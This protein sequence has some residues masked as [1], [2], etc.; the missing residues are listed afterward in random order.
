[1]RTCIQIPRTHAK[2]GKAAVSGIPV[3]RKQDGF[4]EPV[5]HPA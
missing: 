1:M 3:L 4:L 2:V 5:G